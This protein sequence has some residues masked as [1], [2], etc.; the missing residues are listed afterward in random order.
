VVCEHP[1][2]RIVN[3]LGILV[4]VVLLAVILLSTVKVEQMADVQ[5]AGSILGDNILPYLL[6][7]SF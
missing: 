7:W 2:A 5:S 4:G 6:P 3:A 1:D